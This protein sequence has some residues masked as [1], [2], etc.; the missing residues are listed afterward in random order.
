[1]GFRGTGSLYE[2]GMES[3]FNEF[4]TFSSSEKVGTAS[5]AVTPRLPSRNVLRLHQGKEHTRA[6]FRMLRRLPDNHDN[7]GAKAANRDSIDS[8]IAFIDAHSFAHPILA[9]LDDE[10]FAVIEIES[11][12]RN[13]FADITFFDGDQVECYVRIANAE[14]VMCRGHWQDAK[15]SDLFE[16]FGVR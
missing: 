1:M 6:R 12:D 8:A 7:D 16:K 9:T 13:T 14:S 3:N 4:L 2:T 15:I 11:A 10:G 5:A